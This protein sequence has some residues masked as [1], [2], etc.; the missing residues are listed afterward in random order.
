MLRAIGSLVP[1][2]F[3]RAL[4]FPEIIGVEGT[5]E[6][7]LPADAEAHL[8]LGAARALEQLAALVGDVA[9][10]DSRC[11]PVCHRGAGDC[12]RSALECCLNP[13]ANRYARRAIFLGCASIAL[14]NIVVLAQG[15]GNEKPR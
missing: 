13:Q 8:P 12:A 9:R 14:G 5:L 15:Q 11:G 1:D 4:R 3:C 10:G 7:P 2:G 6:L